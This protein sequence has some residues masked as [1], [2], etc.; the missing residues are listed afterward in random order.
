M[1]VS[2]LEEIAIY[3]AGGDVVWSALDERDRWLYR[4]SAR[5]ILAITNQWQPIETA[6]EGEFVLVTYTQGE[7][8]EILEAKSIEGEWVFDE[9]GYYPI[10]K[11]THWM[12]RPTPPTN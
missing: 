8:Y 12:H 6:P 3:L 4:H 11:P 1:A 10:E 9:D 5:D 7:T 2:K